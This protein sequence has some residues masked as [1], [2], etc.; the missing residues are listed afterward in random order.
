MAAAIGA[1]VLARKRSDYRP[2]AIFLGAVACANFLRAALAALIFNPERAAM[3]AAGLD[4]ALVPFTGAA[5]VAAHVEV[6]AFLVW[7]AGL[8]AV[9]IAVYLQRR[10]WLVGVAWALCSIG[11]AYAYP[12]TRGDVLRRCYLAAELAALTVAAGAIITWAWK[13]EPPTLPRGA[14]LCI[15]AVDFGTLIGPYLGNPFLTW[16]RAQALYLVLYIALVVIQG[17]SLWSSRTS[18]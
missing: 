17:G 2:I 1:A 15:V 8:A 16:E 11:I 4:P 6:A 7:S 18:N 5:R 10:P 12:I 3:R 14:V 13:R 9:T